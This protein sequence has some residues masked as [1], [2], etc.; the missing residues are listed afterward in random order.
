[1]YNYILSFFTPFR[2]EDAKL[3]AQSSL[4]TAHKAGV[5]NEKKCKQK[6]PYPFNEEFRKGYKSAWIDNIKDYTP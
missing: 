5:L 4:I 1:M 2:I 3:A 6:H